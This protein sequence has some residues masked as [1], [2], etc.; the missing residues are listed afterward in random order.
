MDAACRR[1]RAA[2]AA[3]LEEEVDMLRDG[4]EL[5][6][7][8]ALDYVKRASDVDQRDA[9]SFRNFPPGDFRVLTLGIPA[10]DTFSCS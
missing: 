7:A 4:C 10:T 8:Q 6:A 2:A 3:V 9:V 5:I 1:K